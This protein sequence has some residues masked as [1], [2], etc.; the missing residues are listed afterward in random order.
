[1]T[2][3]YFSTSEASKHSY[4]SVPKVLLTSPVFKDLSCDTKM[5]YSMMLDRMSLSLK[6]GW[7]DDKKRV[8]IYFTLEDVMA[9]LC[10]GKDKAIK[11]L[12]ELD[13]NAGLIERVKQGQGRPTKIYVKNFT[14][15][16]AEVL[17]SEKPKSENASDTK[18]AVRNQS[19][20]ERT[21]VSAQ[22][23]IVSPVSEV[24]KTEVKTS[25]I[26]TSRLRKNR[27]ADCGKTDTS[28]TEYSKPEMSKP[29]INN[30]EPVA[31]LEIYPSHPSWWKGQDRKIARQQ[32][33]KNIGYGKLETTLSANDSDL[34]DELVEVI[35]DVLL[36]QK[37]KMRIGGELLHTV[38]VKARF[39]TLDLAHVA[40]VLDAVGKTD[41]EIRNMR[42]YLITTLYNAST[43]VAHYRQSQS[44]FDARVQTEVSSW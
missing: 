5:L 3:S 32:V 20:Q 37:Q 35:C 16:E 42:A 30:L 39:A 15:E 19:E 24:G 43:T 7:I 17:T 12:A 4:F 40:Y 21:V 9:N 25:E 2:L 18:Y 10:C 6:N 36:S 23:T 28:N 8:Y 22:N 34:L 13:K 11:V 26:P 33:Q 41:T 38:D 1:M 29:E 31:H 44:N 14:L 27:S